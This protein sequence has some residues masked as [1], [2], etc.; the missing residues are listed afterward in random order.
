MT[1]KPY[2]TPL[3]LSLAS[4]GAI[5][6]AV[7]WAAHVHA[8]DRPPA[9]Q[10]SVSSNRTAP[11]NA[12]SSDIKPDPNVVYGRLPNGLRYALVQNAH[13]ENQVVV[14]LGF[15]FGSAAEADEE[16]GLAHFIE[17]MAFNGTTHVPEGQ[18]VPMLEKLGLSFGADTNASTGFTRTT[19][20]LDLPNATP[21]LLEQ[22]LFLMRETASEMRFDA[23]AVDRERGIVLAEM[24]QRDNFAMQAQKARNAFF[25]PGSYL[26][27]RFPIGR[28]EVI[29]KAS[30]QQMRSLYR[31]WY[32]PDRAQLVIVGP[33]DITATEKMLTARFGNWVGETSVISKRELPDLDE[34]QIAQNNLAKTDYFTHPSSTELAVFTQLLNDQKRFDTRANLLVNLKMEVAASVIADRLNRR[35]RAE[36]LPLLGASLIFEPGLCDRY[37]RLGFSVAAKDGKMADIIPVMEQ[38]I[39]QAITFGFTKQEIDEQKRNITT[40]YANAKRGADT[41]Q[42]TSLANS[43]IDIDDNS[44]N[45]PADLN[46]VWLNLQGTVTADSVLRE[47]KGWH[48]RLVAPRLFFEGKQPM[49]EALLLNSYNNSRKVVV[50]PPEKRSIS[51]FTYTDWGTAGQ[52]ISDSNITDLGIRT[53]R[54]ANNVL[55]NIKK[56]DFE[57]GRIRYTVRIAGGKLA[58]G[59]DNAP[60]SSLFNAT[61]ISA[62]LKAHGYSDLAALFAGSTVDFA[63]GMSDEYFS[64]TGAIAPEEIEKQMQLLAAYIYHPGWREEALRLYRRPLEESYARMD[65]TPASALDVAYNRILTAND[66]R[67]SL[68]PLERAQAMDFIE[69]Q[70]ALGNMLTE[71]RLEIGLVGD[72]DEATA[73]AA[74]ARSFGAMPKRKDTAPND[75]A[76]RQSAWSGN[77]GVH[78]ISHR[79]EAT[80]LAWRKSWSIGDGRVLKDRLTM[81][82]LSRV[83]DVMLLD[84]L[85][86]RLGASYGA[87]ASAYM[88]DVYP[89][90]GLF[91]IST[92]GKVDDI[93]VIEKAVDS[94]MARLLSGDIDVATFERARAPVIEAYRDWRSDNDTWVGL[95]AFAQTKPD[96]LDDFRQ[97]ESVFRAIT[98]ADILAAARRSFKDK[99]SYIFRS[100][101][102]NSPATSPVGSS[103]SEIIP[104][105]AKETKQNSTAQFQPRDD[106]KDE[107]KEK[108]DLDL[109]INTIA[110]T[111]KFITVGE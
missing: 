27:D 92:Q 67:F 38:A 90:R 9:T 54:F 77:T 4:T 36:D 8:Q 106:A 110:P 20:K 6:A 79:G 55:L 86:E 19:Y 87:S 61:Y 42:S 88:S 22:A 34:C 57:K 30:A 75:A 95:A 111:Q 13:P 51:K 74:V 45:H 83:V 15:D 3:A 32:R 56:T 85:R 96:E 68:I 72:V 62:G 26:A 97:N 46:A 29:E 17:H 48:K 41:R 39:R 12:D 108:A 109:A 64:S 50:T 70:A 78:T 52:I 100:V 104:T 33:I 71:N 91:T 93:A 31:T 40:R 18:M 80:Q 59:R 69:L 47:F 49:T 105:V 58:L 1:S 65:A 24:R 16:Q 35:L 23:G 14:R 98:V 89:D 11:W 81:D 21:Q 43:L 63:F 107:G 10:V 37:A 44:F 101:P 5:S 94:V 103:S 73:I 76:A 99:E 60:L 28:Q 53:I 102:D 66:P 84:E 7:I 82:L 2:S 25:Y